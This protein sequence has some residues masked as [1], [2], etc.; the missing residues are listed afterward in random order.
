M[1]D[2]L[3][4]NKIAYKINPKDYMEYS[5]IKAHYL[6]EYT[7]IDI[8][9]LFLK[10]ED[11]PSFKDEHK[12]CSFFKK[13]EV[14]YTRGTSKTTLLFIKQIIVEG[15]K[16]TDQKIIYISPS[17]KP[18]PDDNLLEGN[19]VINMQGLKT[20]S[21]PAADPEP[22]STPHQEVAATTTI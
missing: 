18:N 8:F 17:F 19:E 22:A 5:K 4:D 16:E 13:H 14:D 10:K 9:Y 12:L 6:M 1:K 15:N 21:E 3:E 11:Y 20:D 7:D 2:I